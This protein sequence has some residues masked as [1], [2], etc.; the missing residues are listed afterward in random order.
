MF[1]YRP[2][3]PGGRKPLPTPPARGRSAD[4]AAVATFPERPLERE[5]PVVG[6]RRAA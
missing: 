4:G 1:L 3:Y 5:R 6:A 2:E